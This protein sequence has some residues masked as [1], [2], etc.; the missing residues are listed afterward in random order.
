MRRALRN[1]ATSFV[2]CWKKE[3]NW[4]GVW[5][6]LP[7]ALLRPLAGALLIFVMVRAASAPPGYFAPAYLGNAFFQLVPAV[8]GGL[9]WAVIEDRERYQMFKYI[10]LAPGNVVPWLMGHGLARAAHAAIGVAALAAAGVAFLGVRTPEFHPAL[11]AVTLAL[12]TACLLFLSLA[13]AGLALLVARHGHFMTESIGGVFFL[14][15]GAVFPIDILPAWIRPLAFASPVTWWL[16]LLRRSLG[17]RFG[18]A[19]DGVSTPAALALLA[20]FTVLS[21]FLGRA[22][23]FA[24]ERRARWKGLLD[25][26]T[27]Y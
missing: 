21:A 20:G 25:A 19:L 2:L 27:A 16:E 1:A 17:L 23:W 8:L 6:Y 26:T 24:G 14:F 11:L 12:G 7:F 18:S 3:T 4:A 13:L 15:S 5:V 9:A 10:Y 22:A